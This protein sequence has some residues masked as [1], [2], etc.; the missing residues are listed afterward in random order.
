MAGAV[1]T[2]AGLMWGHVFPINKNLWTSSFVLLTAGLAL[3]CLALCYWIL[4]VEHWRGRW[5]TFFLVFGMNPIA[6]YVF[7]DAISHSLYRFSAAGLSWQDV[8]YQNGFEPFV[9]PA[10]ASLLYAICY[11]LLCWSAMWLL[12]RKRIFLKV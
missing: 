9:G 6:A 11:V 5:T 3:L 10:N 7:A 8:L 2:L 12:Y 4:D 1:A